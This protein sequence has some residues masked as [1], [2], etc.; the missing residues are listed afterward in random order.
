MLLPHSLLTYERM[1][2]DSDKMGEGVFRK[3]EY[4]EG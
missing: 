4:E 3:N 2:I 1:G